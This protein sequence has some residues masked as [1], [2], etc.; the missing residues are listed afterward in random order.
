ME[1]DSNT[2]TVQSVYMC[3]GYFG[4]CAGVLFI[5]SMCAC[6]HDVH[7]EYIL[8]SICDQ[9][10]NSCKLSELHRRTPPPNSFCAP[11]C[12]VVMI[13]L[14]TLQ[15]SSPFKYISSN[16]KQPM[17]ITNSIEQ[18]M[19]SVAPDSYS[20]YNFNIVVWLMPVS[21]YIQILHLRNQHRSL[22]V[23]VCE[24]F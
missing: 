2:K 19:L 9:A 11:K 20:Y 17:E 14:L 10:T 18:T 6:T 3:T 21:G 23:C 1:D 16:C 5:P 8:N 12:L 13:K 4:P 7:N 24:Q 15:R 22:L